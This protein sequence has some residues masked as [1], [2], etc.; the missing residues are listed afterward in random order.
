ME[1]DK[2]DIEIL[3]FI[4]EK[5][6]QSKGTIWS[7]SLTENGYLT[8]PTEKAKEYEF[9]RLLNI[10]REYN[11]AKPTEGTN[12]W[13]FVEL[14]ENTLN[15]KNSGGFSKLYQDELD[16]IEKSENTEKLKNKNL[17]LQNENFE[18]LQTIRE[19][20]SKIRH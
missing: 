11:C 19:Q 9:R 8:E 17:E 2:K 13:D 10:I 14:N 12:S 7:N 16:R 1:I 20:E 15:F 3:D 4:I 18:F 5:L 6:I